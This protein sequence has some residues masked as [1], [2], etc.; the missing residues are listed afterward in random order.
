MSLCPHNPSIEWGPLGMY[1]CPECGE[2]VVAG[3]PHPDY[4]T[5]WIDE[6]YAVFAGRA[7]WIGNHSSQC[8]RGN[9]EHEGDLNGTD[10]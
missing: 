8:L 10:W 6:D 4:D 9:A 5:P 1:H 7:C 2:M 3:M